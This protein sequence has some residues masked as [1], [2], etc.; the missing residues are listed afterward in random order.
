[1]NRG[2]HQLYFLYHK[3]GSGTEFEQTNCKLTRDILVDVN[4]NSCVVKQN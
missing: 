4:A 1:M 3:T 2:N